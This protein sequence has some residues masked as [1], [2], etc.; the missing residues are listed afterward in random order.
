MRF[1]EVAEVPRRRYKTKDSRRPEEYHNLKKELESF[2][3]MDVKTAK[4]I[5]ADGEYV[6]CSS[7]QNAI[8]E[9]IKRFAVPV[10]ARRIDGVLYL[11]RTD[12]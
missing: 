6:S 4:V 8:V 7:A 12:I 2:L 9:S 5:L 10:K 1:V 3:K 11:E